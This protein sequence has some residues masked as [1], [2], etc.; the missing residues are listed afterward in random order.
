MKRIGPATAEGNVLH[1]RAASAARRSAV[2]K[3]FAGSS[4]RLNKSE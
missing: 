2:T 3:P 1:D 4:L